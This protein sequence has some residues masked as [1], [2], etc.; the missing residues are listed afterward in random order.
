MNLEEHCQHSLKRYGVR[1]DEIH[2]WIDEPVRIAGRSHRQFRHDLAS[3]P[4][5]VKMF[6]AKYGADTVKNI[7]LDHLS[8]DSLT[9]PMKEYSWS[10][11]E[12]DFLVQQYDMPIDQLETHFE[13]KMTRKDII[14]R[15]KYLG[16]ITPRFSKY[17]NFPKFARIMFRLERDQI[18]YLNIKVLSGKNRDIEFGI[19]RTKG[20]RHRIEYFFPRERFCIEKTVKYVPTYTVIHQFNFSNLFSFWTSKEVRVSFH[21]ENGRMMGFEMTI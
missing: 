3:L 6:E 4:M 5:A 19:G 8:A 9:E 20:A 2:K 10:S 14:A 11:E 7:F 17:R 1:G 16:I 12:D 15:R 21:L 13:G 18:L